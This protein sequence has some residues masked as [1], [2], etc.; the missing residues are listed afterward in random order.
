MT[1]VADYRALPALLEGREVALTNG[2]FDLLHVG[3][4]RLLREAA[5]KAEVLV[6][7]LNVDETVR[8]SKG[9]GRPVMPLAERMELLD[10]LAGVDYVTSFPEPTA[11]ALIRCVRPAVYVKGT[12][13]TPEMVPERESVAAVGARVAI[14]GDAKTHASSELARRLTGTPRTDRP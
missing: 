7:G 6:V 2:C 14:C 8:A 1:V 4:V 12:D 3:H 5:T 9:E 10:A 11:D 13:W